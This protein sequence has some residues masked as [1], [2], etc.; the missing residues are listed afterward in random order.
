MATAPVFKIIPAAQ[1]YDW[2][3]P[4]PASSVARF[5]TASGIAI[6]ESAPYAEVFI[7]PA[8]PPH[9]THPHLHSPSYGW[10]LT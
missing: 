2:G 10:A 4:A 9:T 1:K 8:H 6:D 5:A 3:K 7:S